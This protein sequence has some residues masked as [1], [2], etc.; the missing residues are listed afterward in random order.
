MLTFVLL[1]SLDSTI[2]SFLLKVSLEVDQERNIVESTTIMSMMM[3]RI[4]N[5]PPHFYTYQYAFL[6]FV[7][8]LYLLFAF[9]KEIIRKK[10]RY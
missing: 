7:I 9:L 8:T 6:Y 5:T 2:G 3:M 10:E 1:L 4:C